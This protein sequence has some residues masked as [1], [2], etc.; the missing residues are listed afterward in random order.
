MHVFYHSGRHK[1]LV[2]HLNMP[3]FILD[4]E[5]SNIEIQTK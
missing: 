2:Y 5:S 1:E 4:M 3:V